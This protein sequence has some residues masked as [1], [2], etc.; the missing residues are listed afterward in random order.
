MQNA[1]QTLTGSALSQLGLVVRI[2][3][4][5]ISNGSGGPVER[6]VLQAKYGVENHLRNLALEDMGHELAHFVGTQL[7]TVGYVV[8]RQ[9]GGHL[10]YLSQHLHVRLVSGE[11][12]RDKG[13]NVA[14]LDLIPWV[15]LNQR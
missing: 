8:M 1:D 11:Y 15:Q 7:V 2:V 10:E 5:E 12:I 3:S 13:T 14:Q 6:R 9:R 4:S